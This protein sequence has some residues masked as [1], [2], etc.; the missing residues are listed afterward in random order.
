MEGSEHEHAVAG[1]RG[2]EDRGERGG[3]L[4]VPASGSRRGSAQPLDQVGQR[5][6][7][8]FA[9]GPLLDELP[10]PLTTH[11]F[12]T[13]QKISRILRAIF[14][15]RKVGMM[16]AGLEVPHAH[17]HLFPI[18]ALSDLNFSLAAE[19]DETAQQQTADLIRRAL[20]AAGH[21]EADAG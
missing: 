3:G 18:N 16:I 5:V 7:G 12:I 13:A 15:C 11:L 21:G 19:R 14:P 4:L 2:C 1:V 9:A 6:T 20:L 10:E 8:R 17:I